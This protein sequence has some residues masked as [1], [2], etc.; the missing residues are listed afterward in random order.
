MEAEANPLPK[1]E[2][3]PPVTK[4][5]LVLVIRTPRQKSK[6]TLYSPVFFGSDYT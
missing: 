4:I 2:S 3:T 1:E 5:N 6:T